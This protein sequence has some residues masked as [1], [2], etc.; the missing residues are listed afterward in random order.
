MHRP[1]ILYI[2]INLNNK[3]GISRYCRY[4]ITSLK[5]SF[6]T[7]NVRVFS[8]INSTNY[9]FEDK[10]PIDYQGKGLSFIS[11][12][13]FSIRVLLEVVYWNPNIIVGNLILLLPLMEICRLFKPKLLKVV[14]VYGLEL[15]S[16][17]KR[18]LHKYLEKNNYVVSDCYFSANYIVKEYA[19]NKE[20]ISVIWDCVDI[21][22]FKPLPKNKSV[23]NRFNIPFN[24]NGYY[25]L[26]LGR[27]DLIAMH[28]G[29]DR[30]IDIAKLFSINNNVF[31]LIAGDGDQKERLIQ[32][33]KEFKLNESVFFLGSIHEDEL[34]HVYNMCDIFTLVSERGFGKGEGIPLTPL[35][36]AACGKP[37]IV[38]NED[39]SIEAVIPG[40]NGYAVSPGSQSELYERIL[41]LKQNAELRKRMGSFAR[42]NIVKNFAYPEFSKK[43]QKFIEKI[44]HTVENNVQK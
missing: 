44:M 7:R 34:V 1:K 41:E 12:L 4:Q 43:T 21:E 10:I 3:G 42:L 13:L 31:F 11:K 25:I 29:Y 9:D 36:A 37:I 38:G 24:K 18:L 28:K 40:E 19:V 32:K 20:N 26:T 14:N 2:A 15:W 22:R 39:G 23:F 8:L 17:R 33:V 30:L 16:S 35:E 5:G 6:G 27:L